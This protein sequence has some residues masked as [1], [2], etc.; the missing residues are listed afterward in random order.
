MNTGYIFQ[1]N[2]HG[3]FS[4][5]GQVA[6]EMTEAQIKEHN[7]KL[8]VAELAAMKE[9]GVATLYLFRDAVGNYSVGT[10]ASA[11][12]QRSNVQRMTRSRNNWGAQRTDVWF[13]VDGVHWHGVNLG[14]N[15]I[16]R[17]RRNKS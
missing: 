14:D 17:C 3:A 15:D 4:P 2:G 11:P 8:A 9:T 10:W 13:V 7:D 12:F 16:V 1:F 6:G 5:E